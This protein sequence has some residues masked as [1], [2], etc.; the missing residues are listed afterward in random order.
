MSDYVQEIKDLLDGATYN[1]DEERILAILREIP[2]GSEFDSLILSLNQ[3][4][5]NGVSLLRKCFS[6]INNDSLGGRQYDEFLTIISSKLSSNDARRLVIYILLDISTYN[7]EEEAIITIL[8]KTPEVEFDSL[9]RTL[10]QATIDSKTMLEKCFTDINGDQYYDFL[11]VISNKIQANDNRK[12]LIGKILSEDNEYEEEQA[13]IRLLRSAPCDCSEYQYTRHPDEYSED[14]H[15]VIDSIGEHDIEKTLD[16][17]DTIVNFICAVWP[18]V[19]VLKAREQ[20]RLL[21]ISGKYVI[22]SDLHM[23]ALPWPEDRYDYFY[24]NRGL[25]TDILNHYLEKGYTL[26]ENG[27][28]EDYWGYLSVA[29]NVA[30]ITHMNGL[31][32]EWLDEWWQNTI[33]DY[34][35]H[36]VLRKQFHEKGRYV[37]IR[38]NHDNLWHCEDML[39]K[40]LRS[41]VPDLEVYETALIGDK[42]MV[43]HGHQVDKY[44]RDSTFGIGYNLSYL[45]ITAESLEIF[46]YNLDFDI[47]GKKK[48]EEGW[49]GD[50][51]NQNH[52]YSYTVDKG[53]TTGM[54]ANSEKYA[55]LSE[56][57]FGK[58]MS[59]VAG[60]VHGPKFQPNGSNTYNT[61]CGV[62]EGV[63]YGVEIVE[64]YPSVIKWYERNG[65]SHREVLASLSRK[66]FENV[67]SGE[68]HTPQPSKF[69][70][71]SKR[72]KN[73]MRRKPIKRKERRIRQ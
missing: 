2:R 50:P 1:E 47:Y 27:D 5:L 3:E 37:R 70:E 42:Y 8:K 39:N 19:N 6:D 52:L 72:Q 22:F 41:E 17:D 12:V 28:I 16:N 23:C 65:E 61:G 48:P 10:N 55:D 35:G 66:E 73:P 26:I 63:I 53:N 43:L 4:T 45:G 25:Y 15:W 49:K 51:P 57:V 38:G 64:G 9:F 36:Y 54:T 29:E 68:K 32:C 62:Y 11:K 18:R 33:E 46:G 30:E 40:Y 7:D 34:K 59:I 44:N 69:I 71:P 20:C 13:I 21:P 56:K 14:R 58:G 67:P 31:E 24:Y 60:H